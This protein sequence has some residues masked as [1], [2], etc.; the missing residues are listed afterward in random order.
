MEYVLSPNPDKTSVAPT[1]KSKA[2]HKGKAKGRDKS[3]KGRDKD[4]KGRENSEKGSF[5]HSTINDLSLAPLVE[6]DTNKK[7]FTQAAVKHSLLGG[8]FIDTKFYA[9][10]R[11]RGSGIV[12]RPKAVY[13]NSAILRAASK[14][15]DDRT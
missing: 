5:S 11:K 3:E 8:A 14:Y 9:F 13:A 4:G 10:S 12:D 6:L 2:S 7:L 15:F 1:K